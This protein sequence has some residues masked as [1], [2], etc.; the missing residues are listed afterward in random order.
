MRAH[1]FIFEYK[2][3]ITLQNLGDKLFSVFVN[4]LQPSYQ[5]AVDDDLYQIA[6]IFDMKKR[7]DMYDDKSFSV[8]IGGKR[9]NVSKDN[10]D[11][12]VDQL[13][14]MVPELIMNYIEGKDPTNNKQYTQ[15]LARMWA[16]GDIKLEDLN[17]NNLLYIYDLAKKRKMLQPEHADI[18]R[19]KTYARFEHEFLGS[20]EL[21]DIER[22][23]Q[24]LPRGEYSEIY[25]DKDVKVFVPYDEAASCFLGQGTKWCTAATRG[26]NMFNRYS[27]YGKLY[28]LLP[29]HPD[30]NGEKYQFQ[31]ATEQYM[32]EQDEPV[33]YKHILLR[34]DG[35]LSYIKQHES[36]L[37]DILDFAS[38]EELSRLVKEMNKMY[39]YITEYAISQHAKNDHSL[40]TKTRNYLEPIWSST[41]QMIRETIPYTLEYFYNVHHKE[42]D[43][44]K[45]SDIPKIYEALT[46]KYLSDD[47]K[48][49]PIESSI[50]DML[51]RNARVTL[52][53][54]NEWE[55]SY[56]ER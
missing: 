27:K 41:A 13:S 24:E 29:K 25:K 30:Y 20:Y 49:Y 2:R 56:R 28:I 35:F 5:W 43:T 42:I 18:N 3:D 9:Y 10:I 48:M 40:T 47:D 23:K 51:I 21:D 33:D 22:S 26:N 11:Q 31:F 14:P 44:M 50:E 46:F 32:N 7:P 38:D 4:N 55:V 52:N 53:K 54:D 8:S 37:S 19:F 15:W 34:F 39:K 16:N 45:I 6:Q 1:E 36:S 17:R 12:L